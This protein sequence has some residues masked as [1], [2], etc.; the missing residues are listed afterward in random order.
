LVA[1]AIVDLDL[2]DD[3]ATEPAGSN[4]SRNLSRRGAGAHG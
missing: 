3:D 2:D 4:L 1:L